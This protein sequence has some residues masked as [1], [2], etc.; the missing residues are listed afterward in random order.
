[1]TPE[2]VV[3]LAALEH[4]VYCPRQCALIHV[5]GVWSDNVHTV[6]GCLGH[7]RADSGVQR[8]ERSRRVVRAV[9]LWSERLGLTGRADAV[10]FDQEG[11]ACPVEYKIGTRHR[12]A[13]HVQLCAQALC[14]EEM[15][16]SPVPIGFLWFAGPRRRVPVHVNDQLRDQTLDLIEQVRATL[17]APTLPVAVNDARRREC[18]LLGHCLPGHL[19][20][21]GGCGP[22]RRS[23]G[24]RVRI[25]NTLYVK[26]HGSSVALRKGSLVV[27]QPG[28]TKVRVPIESLD[29]V[30]LLGS[31]R[32]TTDAVAA[33]AERS[34]RVACLGR[35]GRVRF[36]VGEPLHGNVHLR[37]AQFRAATEPCRTAA[38][39]RWFVAGKLQN[40]RRLLG[41]WASEVGDAERSMLESEREMIE[42]RLQA[43][44]GSEDGDR[45]RGIEGDGPLGGFRAAFYCRGS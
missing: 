39:A 3:P 42:L 1:M 13:A 30:V 35:G 10:E 8:V 26:E 21:S 31:A 2:P 27:S 20:P 38:L 25:L 29:A 43:L 37:L 36:V 28:G 33:C 11:H 16:G 32:V 15:L 9:P 18:Q 4:Y 5:D 22:L 44:A 23:G 24:P 40:Y 17:I 19:R 34:I 45:I 6:R 14:L 7:R 41:R 12:E